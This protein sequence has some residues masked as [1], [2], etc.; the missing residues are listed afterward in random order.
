MI[1]RYTKLQLEEQAA[2]HLQHLV[3]TNLLSRDRH[4]Q[5]G[6]ATQSEIIRGTF[7]QIADQRQTHAS[8]LQRIL[9]GNQLH[10]S[11][12]H[13][14]QHDQR[15]RE[16]SN[17]E[18]AV[19]VSERLAEALRTEDHVRAQYADVVKVIQGRAIRQLLQEQYADVQKCHRRLR[20][21]YARTGAST[22]ANMQESVR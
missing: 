8:S 19:S 16:N 1:S 4:R 13:R 6:A 22:N 15:T 12:T 2:S 14:P 21:L 5:F 18:T 11:G 17:R 20:E 10:T 7:Q 3:R 9:W